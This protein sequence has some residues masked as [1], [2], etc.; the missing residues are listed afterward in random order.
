M[1]QWNIRDKCRTFAILKMKNILF[2]R[3]KSQTLPCWK[4]YRTCV[5]LLYIVPRCRH[6]GP[7]GPTRKREHH[8]NRVSILLA[9]STAMDW[10]LK[11]VRCNWTPY[12][13]LSI[14]RFDMIIS[15]FINFL[16]MVLFLSN[17][18]SCDLLFLHCS[19]W[20][21]LHE[22]QEMWTLMNHLFRPQLPRLR[23]R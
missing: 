13:S 16:L 6:W 17:H 10:G 11:I 15:K 21:W 5:I 20:D 18:R 7:R 1:H 14:I 4:N 19:T 22:H 8:L 3:K 9:L 23:T 2:R 12:T